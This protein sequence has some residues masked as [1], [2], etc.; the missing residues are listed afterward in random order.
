MPVVGLTW[1]LTGASSDGLPLTTA[2]ENDL[3]TKLEDCQHEFKRL[4]SATKRQ[5]QQRHLEGDDSTRLEVTAQAATD[6]SPIRCDQLDSRM[7]P[8]FNSTTLEVRQRMAGHSKP[9]LWRDCC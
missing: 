1:R 6:D 5:Q 3:R 8:L 2:R 7:A 4:Q 9:G